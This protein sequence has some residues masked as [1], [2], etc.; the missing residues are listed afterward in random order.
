LGKAHVVREWHNGLSEPMQETL[1]YITPPDHLGSTTLVTNAFGNVVD[2]RSYDAWG[3]ERNP[4]AWNMPLD[5][6][7]SDNTGLNS[8]FTGHERRPYGNDLIDMN[9]RYYDPYSYRMVQADSIVPDPMRMVDLNRYVYVRN[10][11]TKYSDPTGHHPSDSA[12]AVPNTSAGYEVNNEMGL[13][14]IYKMLGMKY[15]SSGLTD[16][17]FGSESGG[18]DIAVMSDASGESMA[19]FD[20]DLK[21][22]QAVNSSPLEWVDKTKSS[23]R[24]GNAKDGHRA[25]EHTMSRPQSSSRREKASVAAFTIGVYKIGLEA[26][27][28]KSKK[29]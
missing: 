4:D 5:A 13:G 25:L 29:T 16:G 22:S 8:G 9:A 18:P 23:N 17:G 27:K 11:P 19:K 26:S 7:M 28:L 1:Q 24:D 21:N 12:S 2:E 3:R 14:H 10:A 20:V 15:S 6:P